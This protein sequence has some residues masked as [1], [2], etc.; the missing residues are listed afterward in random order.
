MIWVTGIGK[1]V[2]EM[3][4][5]PENRLPRY[6]K[7][8][9]SSDPSSSAPSMIFDGAPGSRIHQAAQGELGQHGV[10]APREHPGDEEVE[11]HRG[12]EGHQVEPELAQDV[13]RRRSFRRLREGQG[14]A[15]PPEQRRRGTLDGGDGLQDDGVVRCGPGHRV[16]VQVI[17]GGPA[18][19]PGGVVLG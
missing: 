15:A 12:P 10:E 3:P 11:G 13:H 4:R 8:S 6:E 5:S 1:Y 14:G 16:G 7:Y 9:W 18:G 19:G 17:L 2:T